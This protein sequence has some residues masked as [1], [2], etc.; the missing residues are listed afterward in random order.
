MNRAECRAQRLQ[1]QTG[2]GRE[3]AGDKRR[4]GGGGGGEGRGREG[5]MGG[6]SIYFLNLVI[7]KRRELEIS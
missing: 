6:M 7:S 2:D 1:G 5:E 3:K 4:G